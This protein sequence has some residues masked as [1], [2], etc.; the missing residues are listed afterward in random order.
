MRE[1]RKEGREREIKEGRHRGRKRRRS[2]NTSS[3]RLEVAII[4]VRMGKLELDFRTL[5][6]YSVK[7]TAVT[8]LV[9]FHQSCLLFSNFSSLHSK[10]FC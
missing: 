2:W 3:L 9:V 7:P 4:S 8:C 1:G 5:G 10:A 6:L